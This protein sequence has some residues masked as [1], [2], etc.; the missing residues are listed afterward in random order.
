MV[1]AGIYL[2]MAFIMVLIIYGLLFVLRGMSNP[3]DEDALKRNV[4]QNYQAPQLV[5]AGPRLGMPYNMNRVC[6]AGAAQFTSGG[7]NC[8]VCHLMSDA[9][10]SLSNTTHHYT[11][12]AAGPYDTGNTGQS[13]FTDNPAAAQSVDPFPDPQPP[14]YTVGLPAVTAQAP[15][16]TWG[17]NSPHIQRGACTDCHEVVFPTVSAQVPSAPPIKWG[18]K[19]PHGKRG[20]CTNC[21]EII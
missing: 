4:A 16:I 8:N 20:T 5:G 13:P 12:I 6:P 15:P 7:A 10:Q 3:T 2:V 17:T 18:A 1:K 19:P 21:H 14:G 9:L 11:N